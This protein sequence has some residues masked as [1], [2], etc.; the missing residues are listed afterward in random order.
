M[1]FIL[2]S[3]CEQNT[4]AARWTMD[5]AISI[6]LDIGRQGNGAVYALYEWLDVVASFY[7][8]FSS[9]TAIQGGLRNDDECK[10]Q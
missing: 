10:V 5:P 4:T 6:D 1:F 9:L 2:V 7:P 8:L 3:T